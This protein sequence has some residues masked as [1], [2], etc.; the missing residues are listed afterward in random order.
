[1]KPE[2]RLKYG[3]MYNDS[4]ERKWINFGIYTATLGTLMHATVEKMMRTG[5]IEIPLPIPP[6]SEIKFDNSI[7]VVK[8]ENLIELADFLKK[9][10]LIPIHLE[11]AVFDHINIICG[12]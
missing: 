8:K 2:T 1:M 6:P 4:I 3:K 7:E 9:E 11:L 10:K 12:L 5:E